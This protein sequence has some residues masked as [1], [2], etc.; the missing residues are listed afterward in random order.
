M[1]SPEVPIRLDYVGKR[2]DLSA[3]PVAGLLMGLGQLNCSELTLKRL[4]YRYTHYH[5]PTLR[6]QAFITLLNKYLVLRAG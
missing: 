3:G 2:V 1:F 5:T 4:D 6:A